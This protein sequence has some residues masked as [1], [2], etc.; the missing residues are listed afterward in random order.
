MVEER[1]RE[2]ARQ[3]HLEGEDAPG[4]DPDPDADAQREA[5]RRPEDG[6]GRRGHG[7]A[8]YPRGAVRG[9]EPGRAVRL[10]N[11]VRRPS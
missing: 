8:D 1:R 5:S 2:E 3:Q 9:W 10:G 6:G 11:S 7:G 4:G